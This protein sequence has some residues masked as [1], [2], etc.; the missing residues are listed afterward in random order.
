M[1]IASEVLGET[2][3][4]ETRTIESESCDPLLGSLAPSGVSSIASFFEKYDS[5]GDKDD[6][7]STECTVTDDT[8]TVCSMDDTSGN[9][10]DKC[11]HDAMIGENT[12]GIGTVDSRIASEV[13]GKTST[14][15]ACAIESEPCVP[16]IV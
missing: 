9:S 13:L 2:P 12:I 5:L 4:N 1:C 7:K 10:V 3:T 8:G 16:V 14:D 11:Q 6:G 15:E